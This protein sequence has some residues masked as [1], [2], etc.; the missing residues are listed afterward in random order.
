MDRLQSWLGTL[1]IRIHAHGIANGSKAPVNR[2]EMPG[3]PG[4]GAKL[5]R[6]GVGVLENHFECVG[7]MYK[8]EE[9]WKNESETVKRL[10]TAGKHQSPDESTKLHTEAQK[11][12]RNVGNM[13]AHVER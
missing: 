12:H 7:Y 2:S 13:H 3:S 4:R 10:K 6:D 9:C 5:R 11:P 1:S 8:S